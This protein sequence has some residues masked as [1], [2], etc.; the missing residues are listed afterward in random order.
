MGERF[1]FDFL[2]LGGGHVD[3]IPATHIQNKEFARLTNYY[4]YGPKIV[5]RRGTKKVSTSAYT[6]RLTSVFT[7]KDSEDDYRVIVGALSSLALFDSG[8]FT[9]IPTTFTL[10][11]EESPWHFRQYLDTVYAVRKN[12]GSLMRGNHEAITRAGIAA[13]TTAPVL[14]DGAAG[15]VLAGNYI[16]VV[17]FKNSDTGQRSNPSP[18]S[19]TLT[20]AGTKKIAWT[21]IPTSDNSQVDSRELY[22]TQKDQ[23]GIY[24]LIATITDNV[25][26]SYSED[27]ALVDDM[28]RQADTNNDLPPNNLEGIEVWQER[29]FVHDGSRIY[30]TPIGVMESYPDDFYIDVNPDDGHRIT[31]FHAVSENRMLVGKTKG[32]YFLTPLGNNKFSVKTMEDKRGVRAPHSMKSAQGK[33]FWYD[34]DDFCMSDGGP[35][36]PIADYKIRQ[37]LDNIPDDEKELLTATIFPK[38]HWY[39]VTVPQ[40]DGDD[41]LLVYS[42]R[43]DSW[44]VFNYPQNPTF[45]GDFFG[46]DYEHILYGLFNDTH[47][48]EVMNEDELDDWGTE[49]E[50]EWLMKALDG[51]RP[52]KMLAP[53]LVSILGTSFTH[54]EGEVQLHYRRNRQATPYRSRDINLDK[55]DDWKPYRIRGQSA[56]ATTIQIGMTCTASKHHEI[57]GISIEGA[58]VDRAPRA[59]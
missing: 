57:E 14:A 40:T 5:R 52:G 47:L 23:T 34:G 27:N 31:A 59:F 50:C 28:G 36:R 56:P 1:K 38:L 53:D 30:Y 54:L 24:Y 18:V 55:E 37:I 20:S 8:M 42:Y 4:T 21:S 32:V 15:A 13:P 10:G 12:S 11:E 16:G 2:D 33:A 19:N 26:T 46:S 22:R 41:L 6:E 7:Y 49:F 58:Y 3:G 43:D 25:T 35:A 48:Y 29:M 17:V 9:E 45:I 44:G 51:G 39:M